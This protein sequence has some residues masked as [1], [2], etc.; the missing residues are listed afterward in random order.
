MNT[1][2]VELGERSYPIV[3]GDDVLGDSALW[4]RY[5]PGRQ[6]CIV[7]NDRVAPLYLP[8]VE[9]AL[10]E[11][12]LTVVTLPDGEQHKSLA[13][14]AVVLDALVAARF[15]R[16]CTVAALGGGVT[17]DIAGFAAACYQRGVHFLQLPTTLLAQVDASVGGKTGVNHPGGKNLIGAFH[18]PVAVVADTATLATLPARELSAGLAEVIKAALVRDG[19]LFAWLEEAMPLLTALDAEAIGHAIERSCRIKADLVAGDERESGLRAL[20]NLGHTFGHAIEAGL[21]YGQWLHGEA[22]GAGL[23]MAARYAHERGMLDAGSVDRITRLVARAGLPLAPPPELSG[24]AMFE[25]MQLDK[26]VRRGRIRLVLLESIG[27]GV[28]HQDDDEEALR[29]FL[30][31]AT[32]GASA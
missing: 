12:D 16:G 3:I 28:I 30:N 23:C 31:E 13:T 9:S 18:Q 1:L 24:E 6:V 19:E 25:L 15:D 14:M 5:I 4:R 11:L 29:R 21:G 27:S 7:T 10:S 20:L 22:V 26:K 32:R 8:V 17:G 2:T